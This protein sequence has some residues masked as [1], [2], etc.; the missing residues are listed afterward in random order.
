MENN[1]M[2]EE[3]NNYFVSLHRRRQTKP[4]V[5]IGEPWENKELNE[6]NIN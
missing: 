1:E 6:L 3:L 2:A 5:C 4:I